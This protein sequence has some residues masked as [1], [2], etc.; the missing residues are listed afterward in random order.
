M[1]V[2]WGWASSNNVGRSS[3]GTSKLLIGQRVGALA[4]APGALSYAQTMYRPE[5]TA[6]SQTVAM[7]HQNLGFG[8]AG[9]GLKSPLYDS[10]VQ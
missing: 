1:H 7:I 9:G 8:Q 2:H 4:S 3:A 6:A 10:N 5:T